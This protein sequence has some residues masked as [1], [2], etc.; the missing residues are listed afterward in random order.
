LTYFRYYPHSIFGWIIIIFRTDSRDKIHSQMFGAVSL[1]EFPAEINFDTPLGDNIQPIGDVSCTC[2]SV[3][4]IAEDQD[5]VEYDIADLFKRIQRTR[6]GADPRQ[7]LSKATSQED[8]GGLL[9]LGKTVRVKHWK[10]Y[11]RAD[12][13]PHDA[14]DNI[15]SSIL[16]AQSPIEIGTYFYMEWIGKEILPVGK[17]PGSSHMYVCEGWKQINGEPHLIIEAWMGKK[18][19]M[20]REVLNAAMKPFGMQS[21]VLST[22]EIDERRTRTMLEWIRDLCLNTILLLKQLFVIK[23]IELPKEVAVES[24]KEEKIELKPTDSPKKRDLLTE[25]CT[26]IGQYEG[27]PGDLNHRN[28]NPGSLPFG[29]IRNLSGEFKKFKTWDEGFAYLKDY[30]IRAGTGKHSA[31]KKNCTILEFFEVYA[32]REDDN[33]PTKYAVWVVTKVGQPLF[34]GFKIKDL[35]TS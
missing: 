34:L 15:R 7:S 13:G 26:A 22:F 27:G 6:F 35:L 30:V 4:D 19:Y 9:P 11:W 3:C 2:Y 16:I 14:F 32:P 25:F 8:D 23:N 31:Y 21:W 28:N 33:N 5:N 12:L 18:V 10:S 1:S 29:N 17:I 20:S 24:K